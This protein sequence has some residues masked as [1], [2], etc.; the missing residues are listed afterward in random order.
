MLH[1]TCTRV[2]AILRA[3]TVV[4]GSLRRVQRTMVEKLGELV[5]D[6]EKRL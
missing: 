1:T 5:N 3:E 6:Y 2:T 4:C